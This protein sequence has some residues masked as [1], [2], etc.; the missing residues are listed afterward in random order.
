LRGG[1]IT[2][3][4]HHVCPLDEE[5]VGDARSHATAAKDANARRELAGSTGWL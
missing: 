5:G 3:D 4:D 2:F 1:F